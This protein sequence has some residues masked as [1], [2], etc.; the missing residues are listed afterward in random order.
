LLGLLAM[1]NQQ[2]GKLDDAVQRRP[3]SMCKL[4]C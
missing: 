4:D 3:S 2:I 1:L